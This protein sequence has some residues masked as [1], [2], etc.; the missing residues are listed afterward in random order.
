MKPKTKKHAEQVLLSMIVLRATKVWGGD[1]MTLVRYL[2]I[3]KP[4]I[5]LQKLIDSGDFDFGHDISGI[6]AHID[7]ETGKLKDCF[8]PRCAR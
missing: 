4:K 7:S 2:R 1:P 5:N 8:L 3:C 6:C